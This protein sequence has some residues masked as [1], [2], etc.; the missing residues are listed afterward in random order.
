MACIAALGLEAF[1]E[2][3]V[4]SDRRDD[5]L[6]WQ[7]SA[8]SWRLDHGRGATPLLW[9]PLWRYTAIAPASTAVNACRCEKRWA[10]VPYKYEVR[11]EVGL[12][13]ATVPVA[14]TST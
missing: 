9:E 1:I 2:G 4:R 6:G 12:K 5:S 10:E 3:T 11:T 7:S 14:A 8:A 13:S